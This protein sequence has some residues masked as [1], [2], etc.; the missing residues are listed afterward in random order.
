MMNQLLVDEETEGG[1]GGA[2]TRVLPSALPVQ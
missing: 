1:V 2:A